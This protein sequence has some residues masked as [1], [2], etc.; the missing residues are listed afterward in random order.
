MGP[1]VTNRRLFL[2]TLA[3][4]WAMPGHVAAESEQKDEGNADFTLRIAPIEIEIAPRRKIKTTG[5][6]GG[7]PGPVLRI[8]GRQA[9]DNR[10]L[11]KVAGKP[12]AGILK[13]VVAV[14][15]RKQMEVQFLADNASLSLFHATCNCTW[16]LDL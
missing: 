7:A 16:I 2:K 13:D 6:N 11:I 14:P 4:A 5:Y 1:R 15:A 9:C 10:C 12:T 8:E 3:G